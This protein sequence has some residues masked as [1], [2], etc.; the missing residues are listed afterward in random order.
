MISKII[1]FM[2]ALL[3]I[4]F[5]KLGSLIFILIQI[6]IKMIFIRFGLQLLIIGLI[7]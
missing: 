3:P 5:L 2:D 6:L 7:L 1:L 4:F